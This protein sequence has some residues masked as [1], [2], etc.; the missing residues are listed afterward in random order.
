MSSMARHFP[1][2]TDDYPVVYTKDTDVALPDSVVV[3]SMRYAYFKTIAKGGKCLIQSCKDFH[4]SRTVAHKSL[5]KEF[6]DDPLEQRRFLREARV[7]AMLQH[8]NTIPTYELSRDNRGHY[9]FTMKL[10]QGATLREVIDESRK[11]E[12]YY[13]EGYGLDRMVSIIIQVGHALDYAHNHGV[14]HRDVKPANI[15][16]GPFGEVVLLDW[17]LAKVFDMEDEKGGAAGAEDGDPSLSG[18]GKLQGTAYYMSPE[19]IDESEA[20]DHRSDVFSLGAVLY[21]CLTLETMSSGDTLQ[22]IL[23]AARNSVPPP[24]SEAA[25]DR[26]I[27]ADLDR[28]VMRCVEKDPDA[29]FPTMNKLITE[30]RAWRARQLLISRRT[31]RR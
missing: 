10:M 11:S 31:G 7:S 12:F 17:G 4:L 24:P 27:P 13:I 2:A 8:P 23:D 3:N 1:E 29:R 5:L 22:Q 18:A 28:I 21:E 20:L 19:Q 6:A 16:M 15:L 25:P 9:F 26:G 30:L 14:I